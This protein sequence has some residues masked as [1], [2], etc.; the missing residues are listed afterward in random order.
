MITSLVVGSEGFVGTPL[1]RYLENR[2]DRVLRFDLK[3]GPHED[4]RLVHLELESIAA[5][6]S[7]FSWIAT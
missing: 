6:F 4:A 7:L 5:I 1:C 2:G 3:R